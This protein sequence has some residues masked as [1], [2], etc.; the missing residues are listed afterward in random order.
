MK[1]LI[2]LIVLA[3]LPLGYVVADCIG[4]TTGSVQCGGGD[5]VGSE[6]GGIS[7]GYYT[8]GETWC[9]TP[10]GDGSDHSCTNGESWELSSDLGCGTP[11]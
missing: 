6:I 3:S 5:W 8:E 7:I 11:N 4:N 10:V 9:C 1:K 2:C